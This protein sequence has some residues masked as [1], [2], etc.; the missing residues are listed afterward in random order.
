L[1]AYPDKGLGSIPKN[2]VTPGRLKNPGIVRS[3][4]IGLYGKALHLT[5]KA[6]MRNIKIEKQFF[7]LWGG[8]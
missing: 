7:I 4:D 8:M 2:A 6:I 1:E 3:A 5:F